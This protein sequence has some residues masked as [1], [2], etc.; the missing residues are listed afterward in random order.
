VHIFYRS[1]VPTITI[2]LPL[3][4]WWCAEVGLVLLVVPGLKALLAGLLIAGVLLL[5][6]VLNLVQKE[7]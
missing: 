7:Q 3:N 5:V 4:C 1:E 6:V 2:I